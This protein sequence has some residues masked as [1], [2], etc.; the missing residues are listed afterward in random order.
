MN[1]DIWRIIRDEVNLRIGA[2]QSLEP[3]LYQLV[4]SQDSL[5]NS[6]ASVIASNLIAMLYHQTKLKNLFWKFIINV[7]I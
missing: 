7:I 4:L 1:K 2:E 6:V 5:K 3:Y